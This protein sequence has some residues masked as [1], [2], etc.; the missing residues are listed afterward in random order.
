[1]TFFKENFTKYDKISHVKNFERW[2]KIKI[3]KFCQPKEFL[4][5]IKKFHVKMYRTEKK[6]F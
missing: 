2:H 6:N 1:M 5:K 4:Q 3:T